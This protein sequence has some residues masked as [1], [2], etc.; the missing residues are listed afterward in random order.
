[1]INRLNIY[2]HKRIPIESITVKILTC[3]LDEKTE[4]KMYLLQ[5]LTKKSNYLCTFGLCNCI[6]LLFVLIVCEVQVG[7]CKKEC[8]CRLGKVIYLYTCYLFSVIRYQ[9][10]QTPDIFNFFKQQ[11]DKKTG[12]LNTN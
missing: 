3:A 11:S 9:G 8:I 1:M 2:E 5:Q 7:G 4:I 12:I 10:T 6:D